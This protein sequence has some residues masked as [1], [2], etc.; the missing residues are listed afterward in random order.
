MGGKLT[1][2]KPAK[3]AP[4]DRT[5]AKV[6]QHV[7]DDEGTCTDRHK[8]GSPRVDAAARDQF[9]KQDRKHNRREPMHSG[10]RIFRVPKCKPEGKAG[11]ADHKRVEC[12]REKQ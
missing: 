6:E 5:V 4:E 12:C 10:R 7:I 11:P 3:T 9:E 1:L 8:H 2:A